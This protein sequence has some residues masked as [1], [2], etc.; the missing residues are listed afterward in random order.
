MWDMKGITKYNT[1]LEKHEEK[2]SRVR[3]IIYVKF[4]DQS[5]L[6]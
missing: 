4:A 2:K 6:S 5:L 3:D 1:E